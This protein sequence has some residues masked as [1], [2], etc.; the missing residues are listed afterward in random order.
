LIA[1]GGVVPLYSKVTTIQPGEWV[2]IYGAN[3]A[4]GKTTWNGNFPISLGGSSV[5]IDGQAAYLIYVSPTQINLQAPDDTATGPVPV[6]VT[7]AAGTFTSTV[8]LAQFAPSLFLL[9]SVHVDGIILRSDGSGAYGGG[10]YDILG[11]TGNSLGY[12]TVAAKAGDSVALFGTGFGPTNP[13]VPAGQAFSSAA[14]TTNPVSLL[15]NNV[16]VTPSFAG[17]SGAGLDQI[18]LT[19]PAGLGTGDVPLLAIV[20]GVQTPSSVVISLQ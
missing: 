2:S 13:F 12:A 1:P 15:I 20:G 6:I 3:L 18:N 17:L 16:S 11:P 9:D 19:I 10:T 4:S 7:T 8:T 14:P 5:T